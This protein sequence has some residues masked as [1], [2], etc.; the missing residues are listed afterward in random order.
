ME[1]NEAS[2][3]EISGIAS[4]RSNFFN[5]PGLSPIV[6]A[7]PRLGREKVQ[8]HNFRDSPG[9]CG[10]DTRYG[11]SKQTRSGGRGRMRQEMSQ[12]LSPILSERSE[13]APSGGEEARASSGVGSAASRVENI[14]VVKETAACAATGQEVMRA[15][16][17]RGERPLRTDDDWDCSSGSRKGKQDSDGSESGQQWTP[18]AARRQACSS[19]F[20]ESSPDVSG[21][22]IIPASTTLETMALLE[23]TTRSFSSFCAGSSFPGD[24]FADARLRDSSIFHSLRRQ[25]VASSSQA[26]NLKGGKWLIA[27]SPPQDRSGQRRPRSAP[28]LLPEREVGTSTRQERRMRD[29]SQ[30][31]GPAVDAVPPAVVGAWLA[32]ALEGFYSHNAEAG[33]GACRNTQR[34]QKIGNGSNQSEQEAVPRFLGPVDLDPALERS[35]LT[36]VRR[37]RENQAALLREARTMGIRDEDV[38][39]EY[40]RAIATPARAYP[41]GRGDSPPPPPPPPDGVV[42]GDISKMSNE[43]EEIF[44]QRQR[45]IHR[46]VTAAARHG[47]IM[48]LPARGNSSCMGTARA[49]KFNFG[50][51][52]EEERENYVNGGW[53]RHSDPPSWVTPPPP[54]GVAEGGVAGARR[55]GA[56]V[57][58]RTT[59]GTSPYLRRH[60]SEYWRERLGMTQ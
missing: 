6:D 14:G 55:T 42:D 40:A 32:A 58:A 19:A 51:E 56:I 60:T 5:S 8:V 2:R 4:E 20:A 52:T 7:R 45:L 50:E 25:E 3:G 46:A 47:G 24:L 18:A 27:P 43:E 48:Q 39:F 12:G 41:V 53:R 35:P 30:G 22:S 49:A 36:D 15:T 31:P 37:R 44:Y 17:G 26:P 16:A 33:G 21:L 54:T 34:A 38:Q 10:S 9:H 13:H 29:T 11:S 57:D 23:D 1:T 59:M 28:T